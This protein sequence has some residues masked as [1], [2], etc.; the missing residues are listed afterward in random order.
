MT[1]QAR[2][3]ETKVAKN[4]KDGGKSGEGSG[5]KEA[6]TDRLSIASGAIVAALC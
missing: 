3:K 5:E 6:L 4:S 1:H 2:I